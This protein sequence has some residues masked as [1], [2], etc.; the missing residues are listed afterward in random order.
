MGT[1]KRINNN[2]ELWYNL[3]CVS[4]HFPVSDMLYF[5]NNLQEIDTLY[6]NQGHMLCLSHQ[7]LWQSFCCESVVIMLSTRLS[8]AFNV[9]SLV[10]THSHQSCHMSSESQRIKKLKICVPYTYMPITPLSA[11]TTNHTISKTNSSTCKQ[12]KAR[13]TG[14]LHHEVQ[15][16]HHL[17]L[18]CHQ[19]QLY[20]SNVQYC[21]M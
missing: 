2:I 4:F 12:Q 10:V 13:G 1:K 6:I 11:S 9:S 20:L 7:V 14:L 21:N 3:C 5:D 17:R 16:Q 18:L 19:S 15:Q 8:S